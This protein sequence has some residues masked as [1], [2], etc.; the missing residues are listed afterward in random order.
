MYIVHTHIQDFNLFK[1]RMKVEET[2]IFNQPVHS[3]ND[4]NSWRW[5]WAKTRS[6][7]LCLGLSCECRN[8]SS[9]PSST[10]FLGASAGT[11]VQSGAARFQ[12]SA[13]WNVSMADLNLLHHSAGPSTYN[14]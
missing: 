9:G 4:C 13:C 3:P 8:L 6:Q 10:A 14:F 7:E 12:A 5:A 1:C 2:G 11:W